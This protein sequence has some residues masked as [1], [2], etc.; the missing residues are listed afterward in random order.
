MNGRQGSM[1]W[2]L[3]AA[4]MLMLG[5]GIG[6]LPNQAADILANRLPRRFHLAACSRPLQAG[7]TGFSALVFGGRRLQG[8]Q[9]PHRRR[10]AKPEQQ[11][12]KPGGARGRREKIEFHCSIA[13]AKSVGPASSCRLKRPLNRPPKRLQSACMPAALLTPPARSSQRSPPTG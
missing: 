12:G 9:R 6:T 1:D 5:F 7:K 2:P 13:C 3:F 8:L 4:V 11:P 10:Q